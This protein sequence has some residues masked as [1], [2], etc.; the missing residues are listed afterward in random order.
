MCH[1]QLPFLGSTLISNTIHLLAMM[2]GQLI[3]IFLLFFVSAAPCFGQEFF[4]VAL[5]DLKDSA[6][7]KMLVDQE[8]FEAKEL[9]RLKLS[10]AQTDKEKSQILYVLACVLLKDQREEEAFQTFLEALQL[11]PSECVNKATE[12]EEKKYSEALAIYL[13]PDSTTDQIAFALE[14]SLEPE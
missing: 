12:E 7:T 2:L 14:K 13:K 3:T 11:L 10:S 5:V 1:V 8:Y 6:F 4:S 9:L